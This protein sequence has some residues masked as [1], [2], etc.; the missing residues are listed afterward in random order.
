[1]R[2]CSL[3]LV[4]S[5]ISITNAVQP[6]QQFRQ[7]DSCPSSWTVSIKA[8]W[9][10]KET[11]V[12]KSLCCIRMNICE[13]LLIWYWTDVIFDRQVVSMSVFHIVLLM[14]LN[15][16]WFQRE[17]PVQ[18]CSA[19]WMIKGPRHDTVYLDYFLQ[20]IRFEIKINKK[21]QVLSVVVC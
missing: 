10:E 21:I 1:M 12:D 9:C 16:T 18:M 20:Y 8:Q 19:G 4:A 17:M 13:W 6:E 2:W 7:N 11:N 3:P 14:D 15:Y 5:S